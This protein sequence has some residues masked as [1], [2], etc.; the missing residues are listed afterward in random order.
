MRSPRKDGLAT[1][2]VRGVSKLTLVMRMVA[3]MMMMMMMMIMMVVVM[4]MRD[5]S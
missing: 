3:M 2:R 4:M 5:E 1:N